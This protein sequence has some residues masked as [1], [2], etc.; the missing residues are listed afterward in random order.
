MTAGKMPGS[1]CAINAYYVC[2]KEESCIYIPID[3][4]ALL[5]R[6]R[7]GQV[8]GLVRVKAPLHRA[9]AGI[10]LTGDRG[11]EKRPRHWCAK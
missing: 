10:K 5:H 11:T 1:K 9:V 4:R 6:H 3:A 8:A 7:L 2:D